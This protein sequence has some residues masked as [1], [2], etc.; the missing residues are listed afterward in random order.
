VIISTRPTPGSVDVRANYWALWQCADNILR[1]REEYPRGFQILDR[2]LGYKVRPA[3]VFVARDR[4]RYALITAVRNDGCAWPPGIL[5][6]QLANEEGTLKLGGG[7]EPGTPAPSQVQQGRIILPEGI[8]W[9]GLKLSAEIEINGIR[10]PVRWACYE[11]LNPDGSLTL[12]PTNGL[13]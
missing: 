6:I 12:R 7:F 13:R 11:P 3:W 5:R 2:H 10:H 8:D 4:G 9:Q 1:F